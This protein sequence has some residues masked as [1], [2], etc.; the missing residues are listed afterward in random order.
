MKGE[1]SQPGVD[2]ARLEAEAA[3]AL[4]I[5]EHLERDPDSTQ[6][7]LAARLGVAIGTVNWYVKR[8]VAK[9]YVKVTHLQRRR[10]RYLITPKG[11]SEKAR[12][13]YRYVQVSMHLYKTVRARARDLLAEAKAAGYDRVSIDGD[14]DL[15]DVCRLTCLESGVQVVG[16]P[17]DEVPSLVISGTA[18]SLRLPAPEGAFSE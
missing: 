12:L 4:R 15:V 18:V 16:A 14:G 17:V 11:I 8:L 9:G 10:V 5:L 3:H 13:A 1:S 2:R 7:D 6:A